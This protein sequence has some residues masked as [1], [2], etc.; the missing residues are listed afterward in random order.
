MQNLFIL[1]RACA[2]DL[3]SVHIFNVQM[4]RYNAMIIC[5][6]DGV[7]FDF[8]DETLPSKVSVKIQVGFGKYQVCRLASYPINID[9]FPDVCEKNIIGRI[10]RITSV[11]TIKFSICEIGVY[12]KHG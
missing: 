12:G 2:Y 11:G 4:F 3:F 1:F 10:V 8:T 9:A 5:I 7:A 6:D